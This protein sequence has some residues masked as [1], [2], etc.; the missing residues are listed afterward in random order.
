MTDEV[1]VDHVGIA[2]PAL[3]DA[4]PLFR[5]LLDAE[6]DGRE[7]V[8]DEGVRVSFFGEA[9]GRVEL[10]EPTDPDA[11]VGRF[12]ERRGGGVHHLCLRVRELEPA[13]R[14]AREAGAEVVPPGVR[15]GAGDRRVAF[16]H[17]GS[18]GGV[19]I[20]LAETTGAGPRDG[21]ADGAGEGAAGRGGGT[22]GGAPPSGGPADA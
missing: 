19:L 10:L 8:E 20:E 1:K 15:E 13:L 22:E 9:G 4:E 11:P 7:E 5:A 14:R 21:D 12:L 2:V 6:P 16:L 18:T 3:E 17:P